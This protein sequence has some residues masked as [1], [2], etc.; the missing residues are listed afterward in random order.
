M[1]GGLKPVCRIP[2]VALGLEPLPLLLMLPRRGRLAELPAGL[3][4]FSAQNRP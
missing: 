4:C 3:D 1:G 2:P